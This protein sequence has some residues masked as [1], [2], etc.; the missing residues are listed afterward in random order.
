[1]KQRKAALTDQPRW[2]R[3]TYK[4]HRMSFYTFIYLILF[5]VGGKGGNAS[6]TVVP[7]GTTCGTPV[8]LAS[9]YSHLLDKS[10]TLTYPL[11]PS[12]AGVPNHIPLREIDGWTCITIKI[13][14]CL[15][16]NTLRS[17]FSSLYLKGGHQYLSWVV[18]FL[19]I[20]SLC[21]MSSVVRYPRPRFAPCS[22]IYV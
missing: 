16:W 7:K 5:L 13:S 8:R 10:A 6:C 19:S 14:Y 22:L 9:G 18:L 2:A 21:R 17:S 1:M 20:I 3:F 15:P 11:K 12:Y 4:P